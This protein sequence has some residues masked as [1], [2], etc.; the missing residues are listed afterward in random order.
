MSDEPSWPQ[1][2]EWGRQEAMRAQRAYEETETAYVNKLRMERERTA[3]VAQPSSV[4][5]APPKN[6][7]VMVLRSET[8]RITGFEE[9]SHENDLTTVQVVRKDNRISE[10]VMRGRRVKIRRDEKSRF[11]GFK[12]D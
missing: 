7:R 3:V 1:I 10:V 6:K 8:G 2:K 11:T 9:V 5:S 4:I 12:E